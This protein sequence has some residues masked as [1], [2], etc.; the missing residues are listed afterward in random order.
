M[1]ENSHISPENSGKLSE[2]YDFLDGELS[3]YYNIN[4]TF[5]KKKQPML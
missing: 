2:N 5:D 1:S 4:K 3:E